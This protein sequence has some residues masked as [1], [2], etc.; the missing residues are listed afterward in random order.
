MQNVKRFICAL[1][2]CV[3]P[4]EMGRIVEV[5]GKV[6]SGIGLLR[7]FLVFDTLGVRKIGVG[8]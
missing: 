8:S 5:V 2:I 1:F 7:E 4:L 6:W 3:W